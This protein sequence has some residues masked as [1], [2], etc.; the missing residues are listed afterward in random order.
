MSIPGA[1]TAAPPQSGTFTDWSLLYSAVARCRCGAGLAYPLDHDEALRRR[2]WTCSRILR[3]EPA[4]G[5]HDDL[6]FAFYEIKSEGQPSAR[7]ATTRPPGTKLL[8]VQT[9]SC[10]CGTKWTLPPEPPNEPSEAGVCPHCH[11]ENG[12]HRCSDSR[13]PAITTRTSYVVTA[14]A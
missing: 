14:G 12:A 7:G 1:A 6:P 10:P 2:S 3:G 5:D 4:T 11:N 8:G 9:A 13:T